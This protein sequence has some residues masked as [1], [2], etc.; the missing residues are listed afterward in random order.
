M[1]PGGIR[2]IDINWQVVF[3][4]A[5]VVMLGLMLVII[6][7]MLCL[8]KTLYYKLKQDDPS[9]KPTREIWV[10]DAEVQGPCTY[11]WYRKVPRFQAEQNGFALAGYSQ[12]LN[13]RLKVDLQ[14]D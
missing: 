9:Q 10:Q 1:D 3:L 13:L 7:L 12:R 14:M 4:L 8:G 11:T 6:M 2:F 5:N